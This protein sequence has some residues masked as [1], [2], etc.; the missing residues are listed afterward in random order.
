MDC[1]NVHIHHLFLDVLQSVSLTETTCAHSHTHTTVHT[2]RYTCMCTHTHTHTHTGTHT[3]TCCM[4]ACARSFPFM[5]NVIL[6]PHLLLSNSAVHCLIY[7][8]ILNKILPYVCVL[9]VCRML[10]IPQYHSVAIHTPQPLPP[11]HTCT[12]TLSLPYAC[13]IE[14]AGTCSWQA[15]TL[16][17][18]VLYFTIPVQNVYA[19]VHIQ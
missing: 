8:F 10:C 12:H 18:I 2:C 13:L 16:P 4:C 1:F 17:G 9:H 5:Q 6:R 15:C 19:N 7:K 3:H 11:P 14:C